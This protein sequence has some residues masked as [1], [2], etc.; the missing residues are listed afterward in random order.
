MN[1]EIVGQ[2]ARVRERVAASDVDIV[3]GSGR[4]WR[5][6]VESVAWEPGDLLALGSGAAGEIAHVFLG[7][8][9]AKI[10][11]HSPV[12]VMIVPRQA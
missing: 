11:R 3:V 9:A 2:L 12:P 10:V 7:S 1:D 8:A 6:A 4:N 5:D